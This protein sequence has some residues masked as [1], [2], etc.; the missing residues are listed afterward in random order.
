M[1][2]SAR[3]VANFT[4]LENRL[5]KLW[6]LINIT[7]ILKNKKKQLILR[8]QLSLGVC[9]AYTVSNKEYQSWKLSLC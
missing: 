3:D 5:F 6:H 7:N 4:A 9:T 1:P 8:I 2:L